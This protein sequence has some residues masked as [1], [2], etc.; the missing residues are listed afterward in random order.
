MSFFSL[1]QFEQSIPPFEKS[2]AINGLQLGV[3][4][5][6]GCACMGCSK[7]DLAA[8]AFR[9]CVNLEPNVSSW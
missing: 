4:F 8:K 2:L 6:Y 9:R 5:S 1:F 7:F 3:W